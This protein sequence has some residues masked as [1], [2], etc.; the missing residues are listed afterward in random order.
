M[1]RD[2]NLTKRVQ[3]DKGARY[4]PIVLSA[5]GR[6]KPDYVLVDGEK[7]RHAGGQHSSPCAQH[8]GGL[9]LEN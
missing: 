4:C 9:I 8:T 6:A 1:H 3:T 2:V 5:N 7:E